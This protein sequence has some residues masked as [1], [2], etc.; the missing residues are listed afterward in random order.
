MYFK[1][2]Q[3]CTFHVALL[4]TVSL[5]LGFTGCRNK[6]AKVS[7]V[8][9]PR[10][11]TSTHGY[12]IDIPTDWTDVKQKSEMLDFLA[13]SP[14][15]VGKAGASI[16]IL[17]ESLPK[18]VTAREFFDTSKYNLSLMMPSFTS[19]EPI[20]SSVSGVDR[21]KVPGQWMTASGM[22][23]K[24]CIFFMTRDKNGYIITFTTTPETYSQFATLFDQIGDSFRFN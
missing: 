19:D 18:A 13:A 11:F 17:I 6:S 8:P 22:Q 14:H 5:L 10:T 2:S 7:A 3:Y 12:S 15:Y 23:L 21:L 9:N 24:V 20:A 16:A 4:L 1:R